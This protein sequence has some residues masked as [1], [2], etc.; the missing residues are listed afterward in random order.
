MYEEL[1]FTGGKAILVAGIYNCVGPIASKLTLVSCVVSCGL[2]QP[3]LY[4]YSLHPRSRRAP[5]AAPSR[6]GWH[7]SCTDVRRHNQQSESRSKTTWSLHRRCMLPIYGHH[8]FLM[9]L[10]VNFLG[11]YV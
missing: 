9:L 4:L 3:R 6:N 11:I 2:M 7:N 5:K 1:G 10:R 8:H